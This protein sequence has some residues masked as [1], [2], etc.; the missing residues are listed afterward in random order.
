MRGEHSD[1]SG[2]ACFFQATPFESW[3]S[4]KGTETI[5]A[6]SIRQKGEK[7]P[8]VVHVTVLLLCGVV[9]TRTG[10]I[11]HD[12]CDPGAP[13]QY[14]CLLNPCAVVWCVVSC[15]FAVPIGSLSA[16]EFR[17]GSHRQLSSV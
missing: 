6:W 11:H 4:H 14:R 12:C 2:N 10:G 17:M 1:A 15:S 7:A 5:R 3:T 16:T 8:G 13:C 9:S